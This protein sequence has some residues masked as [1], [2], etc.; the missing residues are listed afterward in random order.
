MSFTPMAIRW[1][2]NI[3]SRAAY[4]RAISMSKTGCD[5]AAQRK[6]GMIPNENFSPQERENVI[7]YWVAALRREDLSEKDIRAIHLIEEMLNE[8]VTGQ[9]ALKPVAWRF[10]DGLDNWHYS[11][12]KPLKFVPSEPLYAGVLEN[13]S[14]FGV[15]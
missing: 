8:R 6:N 10:K 7:R 9:T 2:K 15:R 5:I 11:S 4:K 1:A 12:I 14:G 3:L 13:N